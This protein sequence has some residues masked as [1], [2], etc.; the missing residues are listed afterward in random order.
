MSYTFD[1]ENSLHHAM[2]NILYS[3]WANYVSFGSDT[4]GYRYS[5]TN[6][7]QGRT[8]EL[9]LRWAQVN[10]LLGFFENGG[11]NEHRPWMFAPYQLTT[12]IYRYFVQL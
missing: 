4:G 11:E 6:Q 1:D 5:T 12:D 8:Q 7:T 9:L 10:S 3:A 2:N